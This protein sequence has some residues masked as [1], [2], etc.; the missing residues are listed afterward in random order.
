MDEVGYAIEYPWE[1]IIASG[2][3]LI[4]TFIRYSYKHAGNL[5]Y[6]QLSYLCVYMYVHT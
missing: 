1:A 2:S 4:V 6:A 3:S 5:G